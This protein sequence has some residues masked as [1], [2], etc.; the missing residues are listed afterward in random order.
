[1]GTSF[2]TATLII[3]A[4][5][6]VAGV[7]AV[8]LAVLSVGLLRRAIRR[9]THHL[10]E[11]RRHPLIGVLPAAAEPELRPLSMELNNLLADLRARLHETEKRSADIEGFAAGPPDLA[12]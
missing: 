8:A 10:E 12:L 11:L 3:G 4:V 5:S 2:E 7:V 1:M 6:V 9:F